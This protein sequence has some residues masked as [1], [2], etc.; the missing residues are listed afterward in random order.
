MIDDADYV[1]LG[2]MDFE[3]DVDW[4]KDIELR[5]NVNDV[6]EV[7]FEHL[8]QRTTWHDK[9]IDEHYSYR[10]CPYYSCVKHKNRIPSTRPC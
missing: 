1:N 8:F 2:V 9:L 7:R 5:P 4:K 3:S 10:R 6:S